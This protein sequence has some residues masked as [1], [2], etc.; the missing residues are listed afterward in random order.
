MAYK[1]ELP[2]ETLHR[3]YLLRKYC[4]RG[5]IIQQVREALLDYIKSQEEKFG[6]PVE[7]IAETI[8]RYERETEINQKDWRIELENQVKNRNRKLAKKIY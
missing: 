2:K 4:A 7:D 1:L 8:E 3:L 6:I 5:P